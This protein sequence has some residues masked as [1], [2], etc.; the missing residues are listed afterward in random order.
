MI[1]VYNCDDESLQLRTFGYWM[2]EIQSGCWW[3]IWLIS[4][5]T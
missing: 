3:W 2:Y 5:V 4:F 1:K